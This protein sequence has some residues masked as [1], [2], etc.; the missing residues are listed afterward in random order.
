MLNKSLSVLF[1]CLLSASA[2][3]ANNHTVDNSN[4]S[5]TFSGE[6]VGMTF[7]GIF[8]KWEASLVLPPAANPLIEATFYLTSAKTGDFTYDSTLP[9]GDWFNTEDHPTGHFTSQ[10]VEASDNGYRVTGN[11]ELRGVSKTQTFELKRSGDTLTADF[12]INR[13]DYSIGFDSDPDAE[14]VSRDIVMSLQLNI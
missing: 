13:L 5:V 14:W 6:H 12:K 7:S 1:I 8:E 9:E 4:S 3:A 10:S 2:S 11:L